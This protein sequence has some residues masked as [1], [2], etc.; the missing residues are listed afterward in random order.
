MLSMMDM[1][2]QCVAQE[3][4]SC[5]PLGRLILTICEIMLGTG[6]K[7]NLKPID[8]VLNI[9]ILMGKWNI[10]NCKPNDKKLIFLEFTTILSNKM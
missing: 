3:T 8:S 5:V 7:R 6:L 9:A 4:W 1:I 10:H 2:G